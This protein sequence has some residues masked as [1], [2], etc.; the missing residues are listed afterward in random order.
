M[1]GRISG[2]H[3]VLDAFPGQR[4]L[5]ADIHSFP[6][7]NAVSGWLDHP[8][9]GLAREAYDAMPLFMLGTDGN[10]S[11]DDDV[12]YHLSCRL[13]ARF[14]ALPQVIRTEVMRRI[15]SRVVVWHNYA[16]K[17]V[18]NVRMPRLIL[19]REL[20]RRV[21]A[22]QIELNERPFMN[23]ERTAFASMGRAILQYLQGVMYDAVRDTGEW[24]ATTAP[25]A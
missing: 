4:V 24:L 3:G 19:D 10:K 25:A 7:Y 21:N 13:Q 17:G 5:F 6:S 15:G 18:A 12:L 22:I 11:C 16:F 20:A 2:E 1:L 14:D 9:Y 8:K 23:A